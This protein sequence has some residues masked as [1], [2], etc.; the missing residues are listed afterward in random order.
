MESIQDGT[1]TGYSAKVNS[2]NRLHVDSVNLDRAG[3]A[4]QSGLAFSINTG[5]ITLTNAATKNAVLWLK[6]NE[7]YPLIIVTLIFQT[8]GSTGGSGNVIVDVVRNPTT[9]TIVS[10]ATPV[11]MN[12]NRNFGRSGSLDVLAYRGGTG[13]TITDGTKALESILAT[14]TQRI[15]VD[16]G[17]IT[18]PKGSSIGINLTTPTGNTNMMVEFAVACFLETQIIA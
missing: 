15:A 12:I 16:V 8:G 14:A 7:D 11:E 13:L 10:G 4:S 18:L 6:N 5:L 17:A 9:G 3:A 1:G 2:Q